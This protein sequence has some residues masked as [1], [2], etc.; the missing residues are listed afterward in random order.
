MGCEKCCKRTYRVVKCCNYLNCCWTLLGSI[1]LFFIIYYALGLNKIASLWDIFDVGWWRGTTN[2]ASEST[3]VEPT[4]SPLMDKITTA[5]VTPTEASSVIGESY[6]RF[7]DWMSFIH[8]DSKS[9][10]GT[11]HDD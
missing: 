7:K 2:T 1:I 9:N 4:M 10:G 11:L 8:N 3:S 6:G 5:A